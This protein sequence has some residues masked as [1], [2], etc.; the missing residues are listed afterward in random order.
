MR[1]ALI[2]GAL[3]LS[4]AVGLSAWLAIDARSDPAP[5]PT[6]QDLPRDE[7]EQQQAQSE[8]QPDQ[9]E[10]VSEQEAPEQEAAAEE[11]EQQETEPAAEPEDAEPETDEPQESAEEDQAEPAAV[12]SD[13]D[14]PEHR[15]IAA[16][17]I[18][19]RAISEPAR[20]QREY[21]IQTGDTL[22]G[23]A[24]QLGV[25]VLELIQAN[26]LDPHGIIHVGDVLRLPATLEYTPL[27]APPGPDDY[28]G[29]GLIWGTLTD[30]QRGVVHTA[31]VAFIDQRAG[32]PGAPDL[33]IGCVN[34]QPVV[35]LSWPAEVSDSRPDSIRVYWRVS[36][37][38]LQTSRWSVGEG[39]LSAPEPA[40]F[41]DSLNG[42]SDLRLFPAAPEARDWFYWY[43]HAGQMVETPVQANLERCGR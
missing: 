27:E 37:G 34:N 13:A 24:D 3:I 30:T 31:V 33:M 18:N 5:L 41:I 4:T 6:S 36:R 26:D 8:P 32:L 12:I 43:P 25:D 42:A 28:A 29:G 15:L 38:P 39:V 7:Q 9:P 23:I 16:I 20:R 21:E 22:S 17:D 14:L 11:D 35:E 19:R 10:D 40:P 1:R 2:L